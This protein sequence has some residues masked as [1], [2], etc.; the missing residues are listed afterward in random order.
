MKGPVRAL[1][2][3]QGCSWWPRLPGPSCPTLGGGERAPLLLPRRGGGASS[4]TL[5]TKLLCPAAQRALAWHSRPLWATQPGGTP[6]VLSAQEASASAGGA[7]L[8]RRPRHVLDTGLSGLELPHKDPGRR[9]NK[10]LFHWAAE[11]RRLVPACCAGRVG[12]GQPAAVPPGPLD[13]A[14]LTQVP[15]L[16]LPHP[17][18]QREPH[19]ARALPFPCS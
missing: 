4:R 10:G 19:D 16:G 8:G 5:P 17:G 14:S 3:Q 11:S 6:P 12:G 7:S 2:A 9:Q 1:G 18:S 15:D 13:T